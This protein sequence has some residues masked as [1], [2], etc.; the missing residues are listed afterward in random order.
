[1]QAMRNSDDISA[2]NASGAG[3]ET[4]HRELEAFLAHSAEAT[5]WH[6]EQVIK[7]SEFETTELVQ[8][9]PKGGP[10]GRYVR[11]VIDVASGA[12]A[13]VRGAM[14]CSEAGCVPCVRAA[15]DRVHAQW[16]YADGG[17]GACRWLHGRCTSEGDWGRGAVGR[18]SA[19]GVESCGHGASHGTSE[20]SDTSRSQA[21]ERHH[22][23]R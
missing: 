14:A 17:D 10:V 21:V 18:L 12:G 13:G 20:S 7:Q 1:M 4:F 15:L 23:R 9:R 16:L 11:K 6:V 5:T 19:S 3:D 8:G 22:A 2:T